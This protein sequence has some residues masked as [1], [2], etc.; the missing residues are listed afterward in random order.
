M[1]PVPWSFLAGSGLV[2]LLLFWFVSG[3]VQTGG[4][5]VFAAGGLLLA[6]SF[7][8]ARHGRSR[9]LLV[10]YLTTLMLS[11]VIAI[12]EAALRIAPQVL[13]GAIANHAYG[14]YHT[15]AGGIYQRDKHLG[16]AV[17]PSLKCDVYWNG[18]WWKHETNAEGYRG[19]AVACARAVFLGDSMIYGHGVDDDQTVPS[20]FQSLTGWTAANLGQQATCLIQMEMRYRRLG[21]ELRPEVVF[22][23]S[24][25]NDIPEAV[26]WYTEEEIE[27]FLASPLDEPHDTVARRYL[28]PRSASW[29][30]VDKHLWDE[31]LAPQL[32]FPRAVVG[33]GKA[34]GKG[35]VG[36][37]EQR[38]PANT[39]HF[40]PAPQLLDAPFTPWEATAD[41][42][43]RLGWRVHCH[44]LAKIHALCRQH[45]AQLVL[46][47]LGYPHAFSRAI[48]EQARRM[49]V[50]YSPAG[51]NV[52]RR[53]LAGEEVYL[54]NDGHWT[55][56][57]CAVI[58]QELKET[59]TTR[60][61]QVFSR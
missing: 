32:R 14:R 7:V 46:L 29:W 28:W 8:L 3:V 38:H 34:I 37:S 12:G 31:R 11:L 48:E 52:L 57:G 18:H 33:L 30:R 59:V 54:A 42:P 49:G 20:H 15:H 25:F 39:G 21:V 23:C 5:F 61:A 17:R 9:P 2:C 36:Q 50:V 43:S 47:D 55:G 60:S 16:W 10:L 13:K 53:A 19:A 6:T 4:M 35:L 51:R 27:R 24:H 1:K 22:V 58:A 45:G 26:I 56:R 44:A 41:E 40:L